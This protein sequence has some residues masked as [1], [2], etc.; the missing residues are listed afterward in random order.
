MQHRAALVLLLAMSAVG[1]GSTE[2]R[3]PPTGLQANIA[4]GARQLVGTWKLVFKLLRWRT[5][6]PSRI[7]AS[8]SRP[9][10]I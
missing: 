8:E 1:S 5:A 2:H 9:Q 7:R 3:H 6:L 10:A 4:G